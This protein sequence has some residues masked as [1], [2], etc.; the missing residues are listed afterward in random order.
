VQ[1]LRDPVNPRL[2][3]R[4]ERQDGVLDHRAKRPLSAAAMLK[5]VFPIAHQCL[6]QVR[7]RAR[8]RQV[9][10][11]AH[12]RHLVVAGAELDGLTEEVLKSRGRRAARMREPNPDRTKI[13]IR[14]L[15]PDTNQAVIRNSTWWRSVC[16]GT[17]T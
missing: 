14:Q 4:E 10:R 11:R 16:R 9:G 15:P 1:R 13:G 6:V 2:A 12:I 3:V 17:P 8:D 5:G 7:I